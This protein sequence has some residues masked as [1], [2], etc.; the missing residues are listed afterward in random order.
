MEKAQTFGIWGCLTLGVVI[1]ITTAMKGG[2]EDPVQFVGGASLILIGGAFWLFRKSA[3][4]GATDD[5]TD[6]KG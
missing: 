1:L 4:L 2:F 5:D 3:D 6:G